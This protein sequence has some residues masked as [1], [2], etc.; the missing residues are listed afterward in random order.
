MNFS[1][2]FSSPSGHMLWK[3][4]TLAAYLIL[5]GQLMALRLLE[6]A[7]MDTLFSHTWWSNV[8]SGKIFK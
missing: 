3:S 7:E 2:A 5:H 4:P 1:L 6:P 8:G